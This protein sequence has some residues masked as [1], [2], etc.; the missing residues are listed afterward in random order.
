LHRSFWTSQ[1][2]GSQVDASAKLQLLMVSF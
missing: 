2:L 1:M